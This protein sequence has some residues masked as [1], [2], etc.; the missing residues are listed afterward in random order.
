MNDIAASEGGAMSV[1]KELYQEIIDSND[2]NEWIFLLNDYY[3]EEKPNI[4]IKIL[5]D[6]KKSWIKRLNFD[7]FFGRRLINNLFPDIYISL[8]NTATLGIKAPQFVYLHQILPFQKE[9]HFSFFK[10]EERLYA[11]YQKIIGLIIKKTIKLSKSGVIVQTVYLANELKRQM[12]NDIYILK[13]KVKPQR[14]FY[15]DKEVRTFFFPAADILYKNH[16]VIY[17]AIEI[18]NKQKIVNF[19]VFLTIENSGKYNVNTSNI[20]FLGK[21][22]REKVLEM[23]SKS[24][25]IFPSY[26]ESYGIPLLEGMNSGTKIFAAKTEV[27]LE[28]LDGYPNSYFFDFFDANQLANLMRKQIQEDIPYI[29]KNERKEDN[30]SLLDIITR[31]R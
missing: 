20:I 10:K 17:K 28:V 8:Q 15:E 4:K 23:Y 30:D 27:S 18:L 11:I 14:F 7:V 21:I 1:L 5:P 3:L 26:I 24:I 2:D 25:L 6:I 19:K 29:P 13:P 9:K 31:N 22:S 12:N 16:E